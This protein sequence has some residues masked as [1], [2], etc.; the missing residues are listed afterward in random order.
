MKTIFDKVDPMYL[1][2]TTGMCDHV[3]HQQ[4]AVIIFAIAVYLSYN[5][6]KYFNEQ[7]KI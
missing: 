3:S 4:N 2:C 1:D 7:S 6:Y 5:L